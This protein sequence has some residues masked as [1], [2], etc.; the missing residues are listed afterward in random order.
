MAIDEKLVFAII[1]KAKDSGNVV[2]GANQTT[3]A[4]ERGQAKLVVGATDVNPPE[5]VAHFGPL[6]KEMKVPYLNIGTK[7][8][9]GT[10]ASINKGA[11]SL[12]ITDAGSASKEL[13]KLVEQIEEE[14]KSSS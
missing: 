3:K 10:A 12:C 8:E 2:I 13:E 4:I 5:I 6:C 9:L 1:Q 11:S 14:N 7:A